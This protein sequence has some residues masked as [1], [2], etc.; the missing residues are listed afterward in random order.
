MPDLAEIIGSVAAVLTT[1][2]FLPQV[3]KTW[4]TGHAGDFSWTWIIGFSAGLSLWL[5]YG[6]ALASLPLVAANGITLAL[7]LVIGAIKWR[8]LRKDS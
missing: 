5:A 7:V 1:A 3:H 4:Q 2:S 6:L 8:G